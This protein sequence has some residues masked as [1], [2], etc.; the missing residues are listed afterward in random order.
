MYVSGDE[1]FDLEQARLVLR[2][3]TVWP[4]TEGASSGRPW[5]GDRRPR[6]QGRL[7]ILVAAAASAVRNMVW[8]TLGALPVLALALDRKVPAGVRPVRLGCVS[9]AA[10]R[11]GRPSRSWSR[12]A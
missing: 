9:T 1:L 2:G 10:W 8:L 11:W 7:D 3:S 12:W 5:P 6:H 4:W